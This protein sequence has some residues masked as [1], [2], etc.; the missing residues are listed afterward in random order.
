LTRDG[1][2]S[3]VVATEHALAEAVAASF[4]AVNGHHLMTAE[5][6]E[7]VSEWFVAV[8]ELAESASV[9]VDEIRR[10]QLAKRLP[11]PSYIRTDGTQMVARD[12]LELANEAGGFDPLP[13]W[14]AEQWDSP[15]DAIRE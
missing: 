3:N 15:V 11:L 10:L 6:D 7:Y 9:A 5:D 13:Q 14:F 8:D 2:T 4:Y 12:L 1:P